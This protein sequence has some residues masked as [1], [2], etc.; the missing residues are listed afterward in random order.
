[1]LSINIHQ[2]NEHRS[3]MELAF[4]PQLLNAKALING[5]QVWGGQKKTMAAAL[6][7]WK[8]PKEWGEKYFHCRPQWRKN[9]QPEKKWQLFAFPTWTN[10]AWNMNSDLLRGGENVQHYG[11]RCTRSKP[12]NNMMSLIL[13]RQG[14]CSKKAAV[15]REQGRRV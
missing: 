5:C 4:P 3:T 6:V 15:K 8:R 12:D 10:S 7:C 1:M 11:Y 13:E 14:I 2:G 9:K